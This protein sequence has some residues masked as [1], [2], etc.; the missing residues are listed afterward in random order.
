MNT[1]KLSL[2]SAV[3][4]LNVVAGLPAAQAASTWNFST[5]ASPKCSVTTGSNA[6]SSFG[7]EWTCTSGSPTLTARA[8]STTGTG[9]TYADAALVQ[10]G[11]AGWGV[12]AKNESTK[13]PQ[14][15]LDNNG[16]FDVVALSFGQS[17][18]L[19]Q[20][21][22]G[23]PTT[24]TYDSDISVLAYTGKGAATIVGKTSAELLSSGWTLVG[25][26]MNV[27][28]AP[29]TINV[30]GITSSWW[31]ISAFN[32]T[33]GGSSTY[34]SNDY[35]KLLSV[36]GNATKAPPTSQT[37]EPASALLVMG[38]LAGLVRMRRKAQRH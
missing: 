20:M 29:A 15:A 34:N 6:T 11:V 12:S 24:T 32:S 36:A 26:Y 27:G 19:T 30:A 5:S 28:N 22:M 17:V 13:Q 10:Y 2:S 33:Y 1:I 14:H 7:N 37:P 23:W 3:L 16:D 18:A 9:D 31:L 8:Y 35:V 25:N 21:Q 38:A 4:A